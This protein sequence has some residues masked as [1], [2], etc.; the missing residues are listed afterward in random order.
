MTIQQGYQ[1]GRYAEVEIKNFVTKEKT[2]I[3]NDFEI[4]FEF[5]KTVDQVDNAS[6]GIVKIYGLTAETINRIN[7]DGGE[8]TLRCGYSNDKIE[9]LFVADILNIIPDVQSGTSVTE[10][11]CSANVLSHMFGAHIALGLGST[12]LFKLLSE[13]SNKMGRRVLIK[14]TNVP[15]ELYKDYEEFF[16]TW[17]LKVDLF[18]TPKQ[19]LE[20]ICLN[21]DFMMTDDILVDEASGTTTSVYTFAQKANGVS[22][23]LKKI[24]EGYPKIS[25]SNTTR[26]VTKKKAEDID[27]IFVTP[28]KER[29]TAIVLRKETGLK[30]AKA[31]YKIATVNE[32]QDLA[33]NEQQTESSKEKQAVFNSKQKER[34]DK[35]DKRVAEGKKVKPF[36]KKTT[37]RKVNRRY[38]SFEAQINPSL[39]PQGHILLYPLQEDYRG[40][41][42]VRDVRFKGNNKRGDWSMIGTAEDTLGKYDTDAPA[43]SIVPNEDST[44]VTGDVGDNT[45]Y[46]SSTE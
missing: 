11:H 8:I 14:Q 46:G 43:N 19:L 31:G 7:S 38:I 3:P 15:R 45:S 40:I 21:F 1:F 25:A 30:K 16:K 23:F 2:V 12:T 39:R 29:A 34:K 26:E 5:F 44:T 10:I 17:E 27:A 33:A 35:Y 28:E 22:E 18:G 36:Q 37:T 9:T 32:T 6:V 42:I 24:E 41:Y 4:D 20:I 13:I